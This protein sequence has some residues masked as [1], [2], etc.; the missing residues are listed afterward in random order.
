MK[1]KR[2]IYFFIALL[3]IVSILSFTVGREIVEQKQPTLMSFSVVHFSGYL[4]FI[5]MPVEAL[6]PYYLAEGHAAITMIILA[7]LTAMLAQIIDFSLGF[8]VSQKVIH[9][10]IS[11]WR[12]K[13]YEKKIKKYGVWAILVFNLFP[14]SS[15]ILIFVAGILRYKLKRVLLF[16]FFGL[17]IKYIVLAY[18]SSFFFA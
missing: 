10:F 3:L 11:E 8:M 5:V 2:I 4:F 7:I 14:L 9:N 18:G 15:P 12:Y 13:K 6:I 17:L 16:S 1:W